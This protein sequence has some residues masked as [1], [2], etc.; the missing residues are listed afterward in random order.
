LR[1]NILKKI[2]IKKK[3]FGENLGNLGKNEVF[4]NIFQKFLG[5]KTE[6]FLEKMVKREKRKISKN[7]ETFWN[8]F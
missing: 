4:W 8:T 6:F 1:W 3:Y 7:L 5:K 2:K